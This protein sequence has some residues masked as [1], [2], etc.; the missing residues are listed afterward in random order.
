[1]LVLSFAAFGLA[2]QGGSLLPRWAVVPTYSRTTAL[3]A[4]APGEA[5]DEYEVQVSRPLGLQLTQKVRT[6]S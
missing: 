6:P 3:V 5:P 4:Q 2:R 1:M